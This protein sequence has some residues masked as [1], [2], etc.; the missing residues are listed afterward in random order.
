MLIL[1]VWVNLVRVGL[2]WLLLVKLF[3]DW[4]M[5][6]SLLLVR[7]VFVWVIIFLKVCFWLMSWVICL[8]SRVIVGLVILELKMWI[9]ILGCFF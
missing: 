9:F 3:K 6:S 5:K 4:S 8:V 2:I 1:R 7:V